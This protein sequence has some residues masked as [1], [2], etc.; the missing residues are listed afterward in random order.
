MASKKKVVVIGLST[1]GFES[2]VALEANGAEVLAIDRAE[3]VIKSIANL[4]TRAVCAEGTQEKV[5]RAIGAFDVDLAVVA[6]RRH[7]DGT[8]LVTHLLKSNG[9]KEIHV[10]VNSDMEAG[11]IRALGAT[12]VIFPERDHAIR[13]AHNLLFPN[14]ADLLPL[15]ENFGLVE[16]H[17]PAG[18][19]GKN[20][21][22]LDIRKKYQVTVAAVRRSTRRRDRTTDVLLTPGP[23]E[24]LED[25]DQLVVL[26]NISRLSRFRE[27]MENE[28]HE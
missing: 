27:A 2:A 3:P 1:F 22:Q 17:L 13:I 6:I 12:T 10:Q 18:M 11:A 23:T 19:A 7:F 25:G 15:D 14:L 8:V 5:M 28:E 20:L 16:I 26:G 24:P 21:I 9:V 4:V